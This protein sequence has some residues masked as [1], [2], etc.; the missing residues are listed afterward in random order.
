M[1]KVFFGITLVLAIAMCFSLL[2]FPVLKFDTDAIYNNHQE[3]INKK[4]HFLPMMKIAAFYL[5]YIVNNTI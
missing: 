2:I 1:K 5:E 3:E 4:F